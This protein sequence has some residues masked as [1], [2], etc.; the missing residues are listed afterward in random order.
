MDSARMK[1]THEHKHTN[2]HEQDRT[3]KQLLEMK[4][5]WGMERSMR[6]SN[7]PSRTT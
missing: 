7:T 4:D 3:N 5:Y 6:K 2:T 1:V